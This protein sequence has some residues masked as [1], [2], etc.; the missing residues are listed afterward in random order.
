MWIWVLG[1]LLCFLALNWKRLVQLYA[2]YDR[3]KHSKRL[4]RSYF[5]DPVKLQTFREF[6]NVVL[7]LSSTP[8]RARTSLREVLI[9]HLPSV[10]TVHLNLPRLF[11]NK[12]PYFEE[13][14]H[15]LSS[16]SPKIR[17][18]RQEDDWGPI[19]K[20]LP[21]LERFIGTDTIVVV[22][23]DDVLMDPRTV[24]ILVESLLTQDLDVTSGYITPQGSPQ[25]NNGIAF[26]CKNLTPCFFDFLHKARKVETCKLDDDML[27]GEAIRRCKL[28]LGKPK[29]N[30]EQ[31]QLMEGASSEALWYVD[32]F[33]TW[34]CPA[35]LAAL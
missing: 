33:K 32:T 6:P 29:T 34:R 30:F 26:R 19:T 9:P 21:T 31:L 14:L 22:I 2:V 7:S 10:P 27:L 18:Y 23:D 4:P 17:I 15:A 3:W 11:R 5:T 12:D 1:G 28:R 16:L 20:S 25:G 8:N 13:D 35:I 24:P